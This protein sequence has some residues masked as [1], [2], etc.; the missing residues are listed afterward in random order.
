MADKLNAQILRI[1]RM[2]MKSS[3][4]MKIYVGKIL[5]GDIKINYQR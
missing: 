2:Y 5:S 1:G 4:Q 3:K